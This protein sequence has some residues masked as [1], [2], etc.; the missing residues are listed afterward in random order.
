MKTK[1]EECGSPTDLTNLLRFMVI[2]MVQNEIDKQA[3]TNHQYK[4]VII[5]NPD[6]PQATGKNSISVY[7]DIDV[8]LLDDRSGGALQIVVRLSDHPSDDMKDG[9]SIAGDGRTRS[10]IVRDIGHAIRIRARNGIEHKWNDLDWFT[11]KIPLING[12]DATLPGDV[13]IDGVGSK[14][15]VDPSEEG[16]VA[17]ILDKVRNDVM[18]LINVFV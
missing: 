9:G 2:E 10:F 18:K 6:G 13:M 11:Q 1:F 7:I 17:K 3:A 12:E 8:I 15:Y 5:N 16:V 4:R 14:Y